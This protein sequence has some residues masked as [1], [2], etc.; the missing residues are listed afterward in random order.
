MSDATDPYGYII[1]QRARRLG[2]RMTKRQGI[3]EIRNI[4]GEIVCKGAISD[5]EQYF[6]EHHPRRNP[7]AKA[8]P[9]PVEWLP[10]IH[11]YVLSLVSV[12][13]PDTTITTR[14]AQLRQMARELKCSPDRVTADVLTRWFAAHKEWKIETRHSMLSCLRGFFR[15]ARKGGRIS[16]DPAEDLP[17]VKQQKAAARPVSD[18]ALCA[19]L[20]I[21][22]ARVTLMI[23][24]AVE[25]GLRR[26][27]VSQVHTRDVMGGIGCAQLFVNGKGGKPRV[28][29]VSDDL[30]GT[31]QLGAAGHTPG[32]STTGYLFPA[33]C[34]GHLSPPQIGSLVGRVLPGEYGMH[35]LRH[36]FATRAYRGTRNLRAV[37]VLLGHTSIATTERYVAV[38]DDEVRAAMMAALSSPTR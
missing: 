1:R 25:A 3:I 9:V 28:I 10:L 29:P 26:A 27:E 36:L 2:Y 13:S 24:L 19:A 34:G 11:D 23:R 22:D 6:D 5:I 20:D 16:L 35:S 14:R 4:A 32:A 8:T 15:W 30:A 37:Q 12:G 33:A 21:A 7:G 17:S 38:D 18:E 31:I